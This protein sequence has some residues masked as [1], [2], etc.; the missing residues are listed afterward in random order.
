MIVGHVI[1]PYDLIIVMRLD[2]ISQ[3]FLLRF[4]HS[5]KNK[6]YGDLMKLIISNH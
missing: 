5:D 1:I 2:T 4:V 6:K 3:C